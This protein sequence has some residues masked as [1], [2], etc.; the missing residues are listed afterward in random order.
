M[1]NKKSLENLH[2]YSV[3]FEKYKNFLTQNQRQVFELYFYN[4]LSYAE[5]AEILATTRTNAYDTVKKAIAKLE[6]LDEKMAN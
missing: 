3:L 4:D 5:V 2:R 6:K 1:Q